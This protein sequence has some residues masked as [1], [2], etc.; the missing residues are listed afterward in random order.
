MSGIEA[1]LWAQTY[2]DEVEAIVGLDMSVPGAYGKED[3][4]WK[5][6]LLAY[7]LAIGREIGM[8]RRFLPT[9]PSR[10]PLRN[11]KGCIQ[12]RR[13]LELLQ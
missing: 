1:I 11:M 5:R 3:F 9:A 8:V 12:S 6:H 4:S 10:T 7:I 2:P 13:L